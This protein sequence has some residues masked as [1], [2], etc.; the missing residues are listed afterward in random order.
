MKRAAGRTGLIAVL[1][2]LLS[3]LISFALGINDYRKSILD[4]AEAEL[5][6]DYG[7][8]ITRLGSELQNGNEEFS[9]ACVG[10]LFGGEEEIRA[11]WLFNT[12][13]GRVSSAEGNSFAEDNPELFFDSVPDK[14]VLR[15]IGLDREVKYRLA[16]GG[17]YVY[18]ALGIYRL[19]ILH[20]AGSYVLE[21]KET[22]AR[23]T[24]LYLL[25]AAL[26]AGAILLLQRLEKDKL[27]HFLSMAV[28][29]CWVSGFSVNMFMGSFQLFAENKKSFNDRI[30]EYIDEDIDGITKLSDEEAAEFCENIRLTEYAEGRDP[31]S[32]LADYYSHCYA[33]GNYITSIIAYDNILDID[34]PISERVEIIWSGNGNQ[35]TE[36]VFRA[37]SIGFLSLVLYYEW[38]D[39]RQK[40]HSGKNAAA[41]LFLY[42]GAA[43]FHGIA[44]GIS[45][46][47]MVVVLEELSIKRGFSLSAAISFAAVGTFFAYPL[48]DYLSYAFMKR[49][50]S[51]SSLLVVNSLAVIAGYSI[52]GISSSPAVYL[53]GFVLVG[54]F[55]GYRCYFPSIFVG[56]NRGSEAAVKTTGEAYSSFLGGAILGMTGTGI[57][58]GLVSN[59]ALFSLAALAALVSL[60]LSFGIDLKS[61]DGLSYIHFKALLPDNNNRVFFFLLALTAGVFYYCYDYSVPLAVSS[62]NYSV[63]TIS[64]VFLLYSLSEYLFSHY[65][66]SSTIIGSRLS[67]KSGAMLSVLIKAVLLGLLVYKP[68]V[69]SIAVMMAACGAVDSKTYDN[70]AEAL[71]TGNDPEKP[72]GMEYMTDSGVQSGQILAAAAMSAGMSA[73]IM[74]F[75]LAAAPALYLLIG[76]LRG[77]SRE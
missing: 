34:L 66:Y 7:Y 51:F 6:F 41:S 25:S 50:Q 75:F 68:T 35:L 3:G 69:F 28:L 70:L 14:R 24:E 48:L 65:G 10:V 20:E 71:S 18:K 4:T 45:K 76:K 55:G 60:L 67:M 31:H 2:I 38:S 19:I 73:V 61:D 42:Q 23:T 21:I 53:V 9:E 39:M 30:L 43:C 26:T 54:V 77:S 1:I 15:D 29:F 12:E 59:R 22:L 64:F 63:G 46:A 37:L 36:S 8:E 44:S 17:Q 40:K 52:C 32:V 16:D 11:A 47:V 13:T 27:R 49:T 72:G 5:L 56:L 62:L 74:P 33:D 57:I 58:S